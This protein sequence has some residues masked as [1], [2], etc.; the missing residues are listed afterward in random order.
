MSHFSVLVLVKK[1][2]GVKGQVARLLKPYDERRRV[3]R[4]EKRCWCVGCEAKHAAFKAA[5]E[6]HGTIDSLRNKFHAQPENQMPPSPK[7][8]NDKPAWEAW[9]KKESEAQERWQKEVIGPFQTTEDEVFKKHPLRKKPKKDCDTCKGTGVEKTRYNPQSKWDWWVIGGRWNG[10]LIGYDPT[11]DPVN[12]ETCYLCKGT[13]KRLD[14]APKDMEW[15]GGCNGCSGTGKHLKFDSEW[16]KV[17]NVVSVVE[18]LKAAKPYIPFSVV[19]PDGEWQEKGRMGWWAIVTDE[20]KEERWRAEV[21]RLYK[22]NK[23]AHAV[24]VDCHI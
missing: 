15:C 4:Y 2:K 21:L 17:N 14:C 6:K 1:E 13:G 18:I 10:G 3:P 22:R 20:K 5:E 8:R 16:K 19:T 7:D 23:T 24:L 9:H 11:T 12:Y